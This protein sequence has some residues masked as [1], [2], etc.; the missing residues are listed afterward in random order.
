M[1]S[2]LDA[3][4]LY[5]RALPWLPVTFLFLT[6]VSSGSTLIQNGPHPICKVYESYFISLPSSFLIYL[7]IGRGS[8]TSMLLSEQLF[9]LINLSILSILQLYLL[10]CPGPSP[11]ISTFTNFVQ[12]KNLWFLV[13]KMCGFFPES[14]PPTPSNVQS[15]QDST[16]VLQST[17]IGWPL[18]DDQWEA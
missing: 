11:S 17:A 1:V 5:S 15:C 7:I 13:Q 4:H 10:N 14:I 6:L 3:K 12:T 9:L 8:F 2:F 16:C 18:F